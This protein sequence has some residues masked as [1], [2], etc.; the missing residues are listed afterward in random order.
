MAGFRAQSLG[1]GGGPWYRCGVLHFDPSREAVLP[2][3][4]ATV[5]VLRDG[6]E[7]LEVFAIVR[8]AKSGFLGG[9]AAFPGGKVDAS[10]EGEAWDALVVGEAPGWPGD[11]DPLPVSPRALAV[12]A[13]REALEETALLPSV[14]GIDGDAALG[15]RA[16]L[17]EARSFAT[18]LS[19][20]GLRL[21]LSAL[22]P[23]ARWVTPRAEARRFDAVFFL[24]GL[25]SGQVGESDAHETTQGFWARP[26]DLLAKWEKGELF[27]APPTTRSLEILAASADVAS[28]LAAARSQSLRVVMPEFVPSETGGLLALPGDP[29]HPVREKRVP[30][31]TRFVLRDGRFVG[32]DPT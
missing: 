25:P 17:G 22:V 13:C 32:E 3:P 12:A 30:G 19:E 26:A 10:D 31:T 20:R 8:H 4:A 18:A 11:P 16:S 14:P 21:D 23:F 6:S 1:F 2:K 5:L 29:L 7:G 27:M 9:A 28:A 24:L 15:L